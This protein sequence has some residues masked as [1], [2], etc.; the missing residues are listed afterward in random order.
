MKKSKDKN[1]KKSA[2][3]KRETTNQNLSSNTANKSN[4]ATSF[5]RESGS[6]SSGYG[7]LGG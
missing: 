7:G 5:N 2:D 6:S 3:A 4:K 1:L